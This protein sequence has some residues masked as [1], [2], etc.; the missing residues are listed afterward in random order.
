MQKHE[1]PKRKSNGQMLW[2]R[3]LAVVFW[4]GSGEGGCNCSHASNPAGLVEKA[5]LPGARPP[6]IAGQQDTLGN[7]FFDVH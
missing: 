5:T 1:T 6:A 2:R 3:L 7:C 4:R